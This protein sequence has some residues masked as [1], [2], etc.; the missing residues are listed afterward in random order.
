MGDSRDLLLGRR[1]FLK[2]GAAAGLGLGLMPLA[3]AAA[4][5]APRVLRK[6]RLGRT[7]L[8]ISD[9]SF[10]ASR[11]AEGRE[12]LVRHAL[13]RGINYFDTAGGYT[14]GASETTLG[15]ALQGVRDRVY[16]ASKVI[17]RP[18]SQRS[19]MMSSLERSLKRLRTDHIDV[20]FNHAV[21]DVDVIANPE[22][23]EFTQQAKKQGKIRFTG[24]SGH[25]GR[26]SECLDWA[27]DHDAVDVVLVAYNF[28][29]E[30]SFF[31]SLTRSLDFVA[32]QPELPRVLAKG[33]KKD[34]GV[35]AMK[36]LLGGEHND[37]RSYEGGGATYPQAAFRWVLSSSNVDAM[38]VSMKSREKIDEYL[39]ASGWTRPKSADAG[40]LST[41]LAARG[42]EQCRYGCGECSDSCPY[43]VEIS[44][45]LRSRMYARDY[46]EPE[47]G[48]SSYAGLSQDASPCLS[49]SAKPCASVCPHGLDIPELSKAAHRE[50]A[51]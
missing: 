14:K 45:V 48:R 40:L 51:G 25:G 7:G 43:G 20:Y 38:I 18:D 3:A 24:M 16:L 39:G 12:D 6:K 15:R 29:E 5:E 10:G 23:H 30:P 50:L 31:D 11:L 2:Q 36:T 9:I 49:C 27:F 21:N 46:R 44:D 4:D 19:H 34:V 32:P 42:D 41:Y 13:D 47:L 1:D 22:W 37:L 35:V 17:C 33:R 8:E 26:L 28:G